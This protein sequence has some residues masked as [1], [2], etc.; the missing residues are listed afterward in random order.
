MGYVG[1]PLVREAFI[2]AKK[3]FAEIRGE[4]LE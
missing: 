3:V 4:K 1:A 2:T